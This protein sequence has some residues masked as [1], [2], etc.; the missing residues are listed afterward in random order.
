M[1]IAIILGIVFV[2]LAIVCF[3]A[4][5]VAR[6]SNMKISKICFAAAIGLVFAF[7]FVPFSLYTVKTGEV[8]VVRHFGKIE[9]VK[10]AG[11]HFDFWLTH[12]R[13]K[14]DTKV[15]KLDV[16][17]MSYSADAQTMNTSMTIQYQISADNVLDIAT[18]Y[19]SLSTLENRITSIAIE[20]SKSTLSAHKA[21]DIIANRAA[22][23]PAVEDTIMNAVGEEYYVDIVAVV[24]TNIDFSDSFE[25]AVEEKMIAE[26][27]KLKAEYENETRV[28]AA[29]A[30]A[31]AKLKAAEAEINIAKA[32]AEALK[33]SAEG[34]AAANRIIDESITDKIIEKIYADA[35]DG[36]LP[37]VFGNGEYI[38]PS[39]IIK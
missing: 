23:S 18:Q 28:N 17:T 35:W 5:C 6:D 33:I 7:V 21:M 15:R 10:S 29:K 11:L 9:D 3:G 13:T 20:K 38:L 27:N 32:K 14:Y 19:G 39:D 30:D 36:K 26:Q 8:A 4:C 25:L 2:I 16:E 24:L 31:E 22:M 1:A 12:S 37:S 34:E